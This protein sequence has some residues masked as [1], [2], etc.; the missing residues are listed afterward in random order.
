MDGDENAFPEAGDSCSTAEGK[1]RRR[2]VTFKTEDSPKLSNGVLSE[3][4]SSSSPRNG[5]LKLP[6]DSDDDEEE[7]EEEKEKD[8]EEGEKPATTEEDPPPQLPGTSTSGEASGSRRSSV[9]SSATTCSNNNNNNMFDEMDMDVDEGEFGEDGEEGEE[10]DYYDDY[11]YDP[12]SHEWVPKIKD[13]ASDEDSEAAMLVSKQQ[14]DASLSTIAQALLESARASN[15]V[16]LKEKEL[17]KGRNEN[18]LSF[19]DEFLMCCGGCRRLCRIEEMPPHLQFNKYIHSGYRTLQDVWGCVLSI[20]YL[21]NETLNIVTH[22]AP[23]IYVLLYWRT[24][25]PWDEIQ[26]NIFLNILGVSHI[27][28]SIAPWVGSVIYH[29]MM[30]HDSGPEFYQLLLQID[31]FGIWLTECFGALTNLSAATWCLSESVKNYVVGAYGMAAVF[32]LY[33]ALTA[34]TP[35]ARRMCFA[36]VFLSRILG[37]ALR[38]S[39]WGG[40]ES[41]VLIHVFL[42]DII[43]VAGGIVGVVR[44]PEKWFPGKL[45]LWFNSHHIMHIMVVIAVVHMN[46]AT[47]GDIRWIIDNYAGESCPVH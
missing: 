25:F 36:P 47:N 40:G 14:R 43:S 1:L 29:T 4:N 5:L 11:E 42:Q 30:S 27:V 38:L 20:L 21:H 44:I 17:K 45:D 19:F 6:L 7:A 3:S 2:N 13:P 22:L 31:M 41:S 18:D 37:I 8:G 46:L 12:Y 23:I 39:S 28:A 10:G 9:D 26:G 16:H 34:W 33:K 32:G 15:E 35:V 24:M